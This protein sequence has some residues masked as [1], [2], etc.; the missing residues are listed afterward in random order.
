MGKFD[1]TITV[2]KAKA[3]VDKLWLTQGDT[4]KY[5]GV[6]V[7]TIARLRE[8]GKLPYCQL[9][10]TVLIRKDHVDRMVERCRVY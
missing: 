7:R 1:H 5:L 2:A 9:D 6:S 10:R 4:A 8:N 3:A